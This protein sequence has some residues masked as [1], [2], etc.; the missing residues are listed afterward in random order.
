MRYRRICLIG[1]CAPALLHCLS[2]DQETWQHTNSTVRRNNR[3]KDEN[4][5]NFTTLMQL[6]ENALMDLLF[7]MKSGTPSRVSLNF[8]PLTFETHS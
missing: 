7:I 5:G 2:I 6:Q 3:N 4:Y 1:G 8:A